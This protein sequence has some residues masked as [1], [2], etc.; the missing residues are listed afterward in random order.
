L[1]IIPLIAAVKV[2]IAPTHREDFLRIS[3]SSSSN[4]YLWDGEISGAGGSSCF[5]KKTLCFYL[6]KYNT[7]LHNRCVS[8]REG[9]N[10][11]QYTEIK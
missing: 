1:Y 10:W 7:I 2:F 6:K 5:S 8:T 11:L 3:V 9:I 4:V